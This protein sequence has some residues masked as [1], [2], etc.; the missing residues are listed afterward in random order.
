[1]LAG[2]EVRVTL[3]SQKEHVFY[4]P[5]PHPRECN[6]K[7]QYYIDYQSFCP[8][9]LIGSPPPRQASVSPHLGPKGETHSLARGG[10]GDPI[11]TKEEKV[12]LYSIKYNLFTVY[13]F[14]QSPPSTDHSRGL[15]IGLY[16]PCTLNN[17]ASRR[18]RQINLR[19]H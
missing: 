2:E 12:S 17:T 1:M 11:Q 14:Q 18:Y 4:Y 3:S 10:V 8:V 6:V 19:Q 15:K 5:S 16:N 9:F 13:N 7:G